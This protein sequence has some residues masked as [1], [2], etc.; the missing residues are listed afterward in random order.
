MDQTLPPA[1]NRDV[2]CSCSL[3]AFGELGGAGVPGGGVSGSLY[4]MLAGEGGCAGWKQPRI[5]TSAGIPSIAEAWGLWTLFGVVTVL[6]LI[7]L[8]ALLSQRTC[9]R[10]KSQ[11]RPGP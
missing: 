9:G 10:S 11:E 7:S 4:L 3:L 2:N 5:L 1:V 6:L 8:T